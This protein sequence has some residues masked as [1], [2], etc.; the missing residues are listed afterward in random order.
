M[1]GNK[2]W[3]E[4][5]IDYLKEHYGS[6]DVAEVAMFLKRTIDSV[7]WK[8]SQLNI[9]FKPSSIVELNSKLQRIEKKVDDILELLLLQSRTSA[10]WNASEQ[11]KL[12][13]MYLSSRNV[14]DIAVS[15]NRS[16]ASVY[17]QLSRMKLK[18]IR[19]SHL[20]NDGEQF[21]MD[22]YLA[23]T[24]EEIANELGV[25][26]SVI[27]NYIA[28]GIKYGILKHKYSLK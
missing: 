12:K 3:T 1:A 11:I 21:V 20:S 4:K 10:E 23:M 2:R 17:A 24:Y 6:I 13:Q 7:H 16:E 18:R 5:E 25:S 26:R 14:S 15:L 22:N 8:A 27:S 9:E 19:K 28:K